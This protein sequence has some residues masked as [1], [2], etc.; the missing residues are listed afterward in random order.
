MRLS[1][2]FADRTILFQRR[3]SNS[4]S[5]AMVSEAAGVSCRCVHFGYR[6]MQGA[7]FPYVSYDAYGTAATRREVNRHLSPE[8][9]AVRRRH[10][11]LWE[12]ECDTILRLYKAM[13]AR[14]E[15]AFLSAL[16]AL[17]PAAEHR[18]TAIILLKNLAHKIVAGA[19]NVDFNQD[20]RIAPLLSPT[21]RTVLWERFQRLHEELQTD[22][23]QFTPGFQSGPSRFAFDTMPK[24]LTVRS[25]VNT[26]A[27]SARL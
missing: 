7:T 2:I 9:Q 14:D 8:V 23:E 1:A 17:H 16:A 27:S 4:L 3:R 25:F 20:E 6:T 21:E 15:R 22:E 5:S 12:W 24:G 19:G 10:E 13:I 26:W 18:I 11:E